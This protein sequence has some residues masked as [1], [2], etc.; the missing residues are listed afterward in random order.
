M[1]NISKILPP[2]AAACAI[3]AAALPPPSE[4]ASV[5]A[6]TNCSDSGPGSLRSAVFGAPDG[7]VVDLRAL[8]CNR[9]LLT[10]G[11]ITIAQ[12]NLQLLGRH[13][14]ALTLDGGNAGRVLRHTGSGT[15]R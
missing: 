11:A 1:A 13:R 6:V 2:L 8:S 15:L 10:G 14:S 5:V 7:A 4:A 12:E 3:C 9:I